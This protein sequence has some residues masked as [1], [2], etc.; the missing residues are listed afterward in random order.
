MYT[1]SVIENF[2]PCMET[3]LARIYVTSGK[4]PR[5]VSRRKDV[6]FGRYSHI[7]R[8]LYSSPSVSL[9]LPTAVHTHL[10]SFRSGEVVKV[11]AHTT[12]DAPRINILCIRRASGLLLCVPSPPPF[13]TISQSL[14][15]HCPDSNTH[16]LFIR[17]T[18]CSVGEKKKY[19]NF[20]TASS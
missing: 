13:L 5:G 9:C 10:A 3:R 4:R 6:P 7:E 11:L 19:W 2:A 17:N 18:A 12:R 14:K 20:H 1:R 16:S 15:S 8:A